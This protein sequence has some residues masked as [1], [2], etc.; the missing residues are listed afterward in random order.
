MASRS[1]DC[2][3]VCRFLSAAA[4]TDTALADVKLV[5]FGLAT[6]LPGY[7]IQ[8]PGVTGAA[9]GRYRHAV[10]T[11]TSFAAR[12]AVHVTVLH[13]AV[14]LWMCGLQ[15]QWLVRACRMRCSP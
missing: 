12:D 4:V 1:H 9:A 7:S 2:T 15:A 11:R 3:P 8:E 5:D 13:I 14:L 10:S 6:K